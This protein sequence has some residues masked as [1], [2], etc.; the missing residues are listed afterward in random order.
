MRAQGDPRQ[1]DR[2]HPL[3]TLKPGPGEEMSSVVDLGL[4]RTGDEEL[5]A[6]RTHLSRII[7]QLHGLPEAF[8]DVGAGMQAI[9]DAHADASSD[10]HS[11]SAG[12]S[13]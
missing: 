8:M 10:P 4:G 5:V 13:S 2:R 11:R 9:V 6:F 3:H 7:E 12:G 1:L